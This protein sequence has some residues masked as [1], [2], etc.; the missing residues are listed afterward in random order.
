LTDGLG[1]LCR[2]RKGAPFKGV[3]D[4]AA[5]VGTEHHRRGRS[6]E[7]FSRQVR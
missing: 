6:I 5:Q 4:N 1:K 2:Q 7:E 3:I